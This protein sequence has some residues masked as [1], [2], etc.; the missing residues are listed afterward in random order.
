MLGLNVY[1][2]IEEAGIAFYRM[3]RGMVK[4]MNVLNWMLGNYQEIFGYGKGDPFDQAQ[5]N[6]AA[7]FALYVLER[8][9]IVLH[10]RGTSRAREGEEEEF[11]ED[12]E[13]EVED[14][15][16]MNGRG[17]RPNIDVGLTW[18]TQQSEASQ[19]KKVM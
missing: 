18:H 2:F 16:T 1:S 10:L 19:R 13:E 6:I 7:P 9:P 14:D 17:E 11:E 4:K 5:R 15:A 3:L 8:P 12:V